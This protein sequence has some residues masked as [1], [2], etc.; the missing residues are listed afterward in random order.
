MDRS[1]QSKAV[2][3]RKLPLLNYILVGVV[4]VVAIPFS[5]L[6]ICRLAE[7]GTLYSSVPALDIAAIVCELLLAAAMLSFT[8]LSRYIVTPQ[9]LLYQRI[10]ATKIPI[11]NLLTMRYEATHKMLVLY[12][13]DDRAPDGVRFIVLQVFPDKTEQIVAAI[14][15]ANPHVSYEIFD[16]TRQDENE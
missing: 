9:Y 16:S 14:Q 1:Q 10:I 12:Y 5:I 13:L 11:E 6:S 7:V 4:C 2:F 3:L 8:L 15:R